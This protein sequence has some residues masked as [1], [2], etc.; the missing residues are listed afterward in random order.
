MPTTRRVRHSTPAIVRVDALLR[1]P[2]ERRGWFRSV[3]PLAIAGECYVGLVLLPYVLP[4]ILSK[5]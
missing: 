2:N 1:N 4:L 5:L 3:V